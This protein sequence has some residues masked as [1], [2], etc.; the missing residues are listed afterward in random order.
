MH[1]FFTKI[2]KPFDRGCRMVL[3]GLLITSCAA[4]RP[5]T[6]TVVLQENKVV[7]EQMAQEVSTALS[8]FPELRG[9]PLNFRFKKEI[10]DSYMQ[11]RPDLN[12]IFTGRDDRS[13]SIF[14][15]RELLHST[16]IP[17]QVLVGW[18]GHEL[19]HILD[20]SNRTAIGMAF[21]GLRYITSPEFLQAAERRADENAVRHGMAPFLLATKE[22]IRQN[23]LF[24][25]AYQNRIKRLYPS[26]EEILELAE[27]L[28]QE[29]GSGGE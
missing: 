3:L 6:K 7:P 29:T 20:Y 8:Y 14:I 1:H 13:Y 5:E 26:Q 28:R 10:D 15:S 9:V 2:L 19:G 25:E 24:S 27:G 4:Y 17:S 11:A 16:G 18:L 22:Y 12:T 23:D 21:F